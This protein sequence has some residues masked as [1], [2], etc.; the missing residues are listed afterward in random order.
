MVPLLNHGKLEV[1]VRT[2]LGDQRSRDLLTQDVV[3]RSVNRVMVNLAQEASLQKTVKE[4]VC[5]LLQKHHEVRFGSVLEVSQDFKYA[6][7]HCFL[8]GDDFQLFSGRN[9]LLVSGVQLVA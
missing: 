2:G 5:L 4:D 1:E 6:L 3:V 9:E 7:M 8:E